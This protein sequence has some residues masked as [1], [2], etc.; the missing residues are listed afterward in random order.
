MRDNNIEVLYDDREGVQAGEKF[1]DA[2]LIGCPY[3]VVVSGK[4]IKEGKVEVKKRGEKEVEM[5][6]VGELMV[7]LLNG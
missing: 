2:D 5:L 7:K 6:D 4:T 3:R 1:T